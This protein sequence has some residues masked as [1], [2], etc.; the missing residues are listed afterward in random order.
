V[1]FR[2][3]SAEELVKSVLAH[4]RRVLRLQVILCNTLQGPGGIQLV[5]EGA[6][7]EIQA[8]LSRLLGTSAGAIMGNAPQATTVRN[9][10]AGGCEPR[11]CSI[12][13]HDP[14]SFLMGHCPP[15][16]H[17]S[18]L[19]QKQKID[20]FLAGGKD[21][22][23]VI[24]SLSEATKR[25]MDAHQK[26][27]SGRSGK[28]ESSG[29]SMMMSEG[30]VGMGGGQLVWLKGGSVYEVVGLYKMVRHFCDEATGL[31]IVSFKSPSR[32]VA[33]LTCTCYP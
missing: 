27:R 33:T 19:I 16:F 9:D 6:Q 26:A 15:P 12:A 2:E 8:L 1:F 29:V 32:H 28:K 25:I 30:Q 13:C 3:G 14:R 20:L 11:S 22:P 18:A 24:F 5:W 21:G 7:M 17:T 23:T 10:D 4:I 31:A